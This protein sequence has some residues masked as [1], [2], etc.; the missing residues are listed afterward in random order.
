MALKLIFMGTPQF[1]VPI[2][3]AIHNSKHEILCVYTQPPKKKNRGQKIYS[4]PVQQYAESSN[5]KCR[6]PSDLNEEE[7]QHI[8]NLKPAIVIVVAYGK[9]LPKKILDLKDIK[10]LNIHASLLP[11]WR[12]AAPIQRAIMNLDKTTGISIMKIV[13]KLDAGP[14]L[15]KSEIPITDETNYE[16]LSDQMSKLGAIKILEAINIIEKKKAN[17]IDQDETEAT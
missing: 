10:F 13:S 6:Y 17:F 5:L 8:K 7:Y 16:S 12:G 4:S 14:T 15:I 1:A 3:N 11:K 9:I 2:L